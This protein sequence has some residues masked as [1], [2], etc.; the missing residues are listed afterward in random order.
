MKM[1]LEQFTKWIEETRQYHKKVDELY[2][3][4]LDVLELVYANPD[5][6]LFDFVF[7]K[8]QRECISWWLYD[9]PNGINEEGFNRESSKVTWDENGEE[10]SIYL[11]SIEAL[12]NYISGLEDS[13][14]E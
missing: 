9:C 14:D 5:T 3:L 10:A 13:A 4:G 2:K 7:N 8:A 1:T 12:H 6:Y 11:D